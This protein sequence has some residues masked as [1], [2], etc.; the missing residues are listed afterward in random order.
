MPVECLVVVG[1][2][3]ADQAD[4]AVAARQELQRE[5]PCRLYIVVSD[6]EIDGIGTQVE[7]LHNRAGI[8]PQ[9]LPNAL[10]MGEP[11]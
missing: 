9:R 4:P 8:A 7:S 5:H 1:E 10:G 11:R 6:D 2:V 3:A